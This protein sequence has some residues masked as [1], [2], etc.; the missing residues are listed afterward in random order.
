MTATEA[1][2]RAAA[3]Y[4]VAR[5]SHHEWQA[6]FQLLAAEYAALARCL[7]GIE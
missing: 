3:C 2:E 5:A 6:S 4:R 1:Q 7:M